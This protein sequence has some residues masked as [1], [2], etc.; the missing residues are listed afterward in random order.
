MS[1]GRL[2]RARFLLI[3]EGRTKGILH[4]K[5]SFFVPPARKESRIRANTVQVAGWSP[6]CRRQRPLDLDQYV[7]MSFGRFS[8]SIARVL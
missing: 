4:C 1:P 7:R 2:L 5:R 8:G 3:D 6:T